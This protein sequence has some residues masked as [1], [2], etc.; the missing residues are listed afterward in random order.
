MLKKILKQVRYFD[1]KYK[2]P[3]LNLG[4]LIVLIICS[5]LIVTATFSQISL[6]IFV[7]PK[8]LIT[9]PF[10]F[11]TS[12]HDAS[13]FFKTFY[14]I[15]QIAA[16]IFTGA[17]LGPRLGSLAVSLYVLAGLLGFPVF[18]LGGG[19]TY[20]S[21]LG[22]GYILGYFLGVYL[23]GY[24]IKNKRS[25]RAILHG[26]IVSVLA[27]HLIGIVYMVSLLLIQREQLPVILNWIWLLSGMQIGYDVLMGIV[28]I[29]I[30]RPIRSVLW[31]AM[32]N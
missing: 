24:S 31:L 18:A 4:G 12:A 3:E 23:V 5:F 22:F 20:V 30:S 21:K 15:P 2:Y 27:I 7:L 26:S 17:L 28:A 19:I 11:F 6:G 29:G 1:F 13:E 8:E 25:F 9:N 14:Y 10:G 32:G 16:V